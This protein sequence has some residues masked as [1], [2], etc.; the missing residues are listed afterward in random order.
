MDIRKYG[1]VSDNTY[2]VSSCSVILLVLPKSLY[3]DCTLLRLVE[4]L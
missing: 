2:F 4:F 3:K 1:G